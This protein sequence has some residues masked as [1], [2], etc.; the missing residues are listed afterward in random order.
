MS[1][2]LAIFSGQES[3]E[4]PKPQQQVVSQDDLDGEKKKKKKYAP[5]MAQIFDDDIK[6]AVGGKLGDVL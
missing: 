5:T 2:F 1:N 6:L 3:M 4:Q